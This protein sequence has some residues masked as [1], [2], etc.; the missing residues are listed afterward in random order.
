MFF[1]FFR[2]QSPQL[3]AKKHKK[4]NQP[5]SGLRSSWDSAIKQKFIAP[6]NKLNTEDDDSLVR[7]GGMV[8]DDEDDEVER[9]VIVTDKGL[10][11]APSDCVRTTLVHGNDNRITNEFS[12]RP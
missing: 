12:H 10:K 11:R 9:S 5:P 1:F 3:L 8:G 7:F 6:A 4:S 2:S